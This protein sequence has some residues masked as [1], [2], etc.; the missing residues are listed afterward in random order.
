[1]PGGIRLPIA[2]EE[3]DEDAL[4]YRLDYSNQKVKRSL[5]AFLLET[6]APNVAVAA[7][8]RELRRLTRANGFAGLERRF[9]TFP[10]RE[11]PG[12]TTAAPRT[13]LAAR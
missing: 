7:E 9:W 5:G 6:M 2:G 13:R 8:S 12:S 10:A 4:L 3:Q 11:V 1:M